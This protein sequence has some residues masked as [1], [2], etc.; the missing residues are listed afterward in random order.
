MIPFETALS[1]AW[2]ILA[3]NWRWMVL[4]VVLLAA[5]LAVR[6]CQSTKTEA[7]LNK[8]QAGAAIE[9]GKDAANTIGNRM[10]SDADTDA[11]TRENA[12]AIRNAQGA[13]APVTPAVNDAALRSLCKRAAYRGDPKCVQFANPR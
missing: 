2:G 7:R 9:S 4:A 8:G 5:V 10:S 1:A 3:R 12:D 13:D 11:T 6:S